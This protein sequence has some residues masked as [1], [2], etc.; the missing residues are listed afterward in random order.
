MFVTLRVVLFESG[1]VEVEIIDLRFGVNFVGLNRMNYDGPYWITME[2]V[3][4][5]VWQNVSYQ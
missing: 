2:N 4:C 1:T 5:L 3:Y